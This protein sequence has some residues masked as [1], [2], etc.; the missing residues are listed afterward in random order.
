MTDASS[1]PAVP[2]AA[3]PLLERKELKGI[4]KDGRAAEEVLRRTAEIETA[5]RGAAAQA[6]AAR[7]EHVAAARMAEIPLERLR[8]LFP[9]SGVRLGALEAGGVHT[10]ADVLQRSRQ[11]LD[12]IEGVGAHTV[13]VVREAA[14]T[15]LAATEQQVRPLPDP[16]QRYDGDDELLVALH[17]V[18]AESQLRPGLGPATAELRAGLQPDMAVLEETPGALRWLITSGKKKTKLSAAGRRVRTRLQDPATTSLLGQLRQAAD[19][20][21]RYR[22]VATAEAWQDFEA[23]PT[24]YAVAAEASL[25]SGAAPPTRLRGGVAVDIAA[26]VE[27]IPLDVRG[28]K[29]T[30]RGYQHFGVQYLI[31]QQRSILGDEMGLGKTIQALGAMCHLRATAGATH[32]LVVA[33]ASILANWMREIAERT[34][35]PGHLLH[36]DDRDQT[37]WR[38][39]NE[40][41]IGVTSYT[42]L[43]VLPLEDMLATRPPAFV[44]V[45]EAQYIKNPAAER[46]QAVAKVLDRVPAAVFLSGTPM[47]NRIDEFCSLVDT[48]QP[49]Q[50]VVL[51]PASLLLVEG[52]PEAFQARL[53]P[54]YLRRNQE[55]VL[56]ELPERLDMHDWVDLEAADAVAYRDAVAAGDVM[57][58][59]QAATLGAAFGSSAPD[60]TV[61]GAAVASP[62]DQPPSAKL[63]R[64]ADVFEEY[65]VEGRK[66]L[67]F[68]FFRRV[69]DAVSALAGGCPQI[70]G[71][72]TPEDRLAIVDAFT[73]ASG[74]AVIAAQVEAGGV[75][76]NV[77]AASVVVLMEPQWK[78]STENQA[79]ARAHRMGQTRRVVVH[80][81]LARDTVDEWLVELVRSKQGLFDEY[82]RP[83]AVKEAS[84]AAVDAGTDDAALAQQAVAAERSR[85]GI[86]V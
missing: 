5:A 80:R 10:A 72:I 3:P 14:E 61:G 20:S 16:D 77:Q 1:P 81:L 58:M 33:P 68:S 60:A 51:D 49:P 15:L 22:P 12:A 75:G 82:A 85:L 25:A 62:A 63:D 37:C 78:P 30:L 64:L 17:R 45:D 84:A 86:A 8:D 70:T 67:V 76:I 52:D 55:D 44:V 13:G 83:S 46:T 27:Q 79:I 66:I 11:E 32:F 74:F 69:L 6:A 73:Q 41:G 38:W 54:V 48:L 43:P 24:D 23:R 47:E 31:G 36:G 21:K 4:R 42:T 56:L 19:Q 71:D 35:I 34:D 26:R 9:E 39:A 53:S 40:G 57:A 18:V 65:R 28:L 50:E 2:A 29:A 7:A 59:R